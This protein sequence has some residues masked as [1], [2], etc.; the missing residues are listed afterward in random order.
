MRV[1]GDCIYPTQ[2]THKNFAASAYRTFNYGWCRYF[3]AGSTCGGGHALLTT[4]SRI[5][6]RNCSAHFCHIFSQRYLL[7]LLPLGEDTCFQ[8]TKASWRTRKSRSN[9]WSAHQHIHPIFTFQDHQRGAKSIIFIDSNFGAFY[10]I[11]GCLIILNFIFFCLVNYIT[12]LGKF[13]YSGTPVV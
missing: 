12:G 3:D 8:A 6:S 9:Q 13:L 2:P 10:Y 5:S 4:D 7:R 11:Y 1:V